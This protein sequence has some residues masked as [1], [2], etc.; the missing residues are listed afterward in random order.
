MEGRP[1]RDTKPRQLRIPHSALRTY[2][3]SMTYQT[4]LF[5]IRDGIA[6]IT[7]NLPHKLNTLNDQVVAELAHAA[8]RVATE[9][10]IKGTLLTGPGQKAIVASSSVRDPSRGGPFDGKA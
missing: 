10:E 7:I 1:D 9:D 6:F 4:L 8:D 2:L 5:E 3:C